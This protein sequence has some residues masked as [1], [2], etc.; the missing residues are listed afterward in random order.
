[1]NLLETLPT[2]F[3]DKQKRHIYY[4]PK[5][6][7][8]Y[9]IKDK[10]LVK[11]NAFYHRY[12]IS[13]AAGAVLWSLTENIMAGMILVLLTIYATT[14]IF[15]NKILPSTNRLTKYDISANKKESEQTKSIK[16][17]RT[18]VYFMLGFALLYLLIFDNDDYDLIRTILV[19]VFA[20]LSIYLGSVSF[21]DSI[22]H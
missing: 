11:F 4:Q 19:T 22:K 2:L 10:D 17:V 5:T 3:Q 15:H 8:A 12:F 1:M 7:T 13:L 6:K 16:I 9:H 21:I 18:V 20:I 14:K